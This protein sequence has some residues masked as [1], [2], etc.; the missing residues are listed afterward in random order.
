MTPPP[1][2]TPATIS[3]SVA[4]T[5]APSFSDLQ[6]LINAVP[7]NVWAAAIRTLTSAAPPTAEQ[8]AEAT[9]TE[10]APELA[11][12]DGITLSGGWVLA[13]VRS[14]VG[15]GLAGTGVPPTFNDDGAMTSPGDPWRAA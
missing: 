12:L 7:A 10:L 11:K 8:V 9:R 14:V 15:V 6:A 5:L 3:A 13:D 4:A 1:S 2:I